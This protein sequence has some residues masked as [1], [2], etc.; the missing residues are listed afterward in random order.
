MSKRLVSPK[1][2]KPHNLSKKIDFEPYKPKKINVRILR[3]VVFRD[4]KGSMK[5]DNS[6][7]PDIHFFFFLHNFASIYRTF[8]IH[9]PKES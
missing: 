1:N 3:V 8:L 6:Q 5:D 9:I 7:N 4:Q 2:N